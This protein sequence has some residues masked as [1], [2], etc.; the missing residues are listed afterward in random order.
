MDERDL[1][2]PETVF[3]EYKLACFLNIDRHLFAKVGHF[4]LHEKQRSSQRKCREHLSNLP[5]HRDNVTHQGISI[6]QPCYEDDCMEWISA[7]QSRAKL[8][9]W[10]NEENIG[11]AKIPSVQLLGETTGIL[12][13]FLSSY[14][15]LCFII[16]CKKFHRLLLEL[17]NI[18]IT[19]SH[20]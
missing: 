2:E 17:L 7:C 1:R 9:N 5:S 11:D 6:S 14:T 16:A 12:K 19:I 20:M 18:S 10:L 15:I 4:C 3:T 8:I 13:V